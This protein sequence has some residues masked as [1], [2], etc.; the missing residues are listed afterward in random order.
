M[1]EYTCP[2]CG[3]T[4]QVR[5]SWE[6]RTWCSRQCYGIA[7]AAMTE[8]LTP[9]LPEGECIFNPVGV[10]CFRQDCGNCGWNPEVAKAR[11]EAFGVKN[12]A[13][14]M[15]EPKKEDRFGDWISV[16]ERMPEVGVQ[17][18][19]ITTNGKC[20]ILHQKCGDWQCRNPEAITHWMPLPQQPEV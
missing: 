15:P 20:L 18:L 2:V 7:R 1:Y 9:T 16:D 5:Y 13:D 6:V 3:V 14:L 4:K 11:L 17:V 8:E 10:S 19:V 12:V